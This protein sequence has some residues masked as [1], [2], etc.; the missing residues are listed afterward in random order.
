LSTTL[1]DRRPDG[2]TARLLGPPG[3]Q[4]TRLA[5]ALLSWLVYAL[6]AAGQH[7]EVLMGLVDERA[8]WQLTAFYMTGSTLFCLA[9]RSGWNERLRDPSMTVAQGV[10]GIVA[11][12]WSYAIT[13]PARGALLTIPMTILMFAMF[14]LGPRGSAV[15]SGATLLLFASVMGWKAHSDPL[16]YDPRVEVVH[17]VFALIVLVSL[18]VLAR[19]LTSLRQRLTRQRTEL[20]EALARIQQLATQDELTGLA[21]RRSMVE[22]LALEA[23][24]HQRAGTTLALAMIDLDHFKRIND[25]HGHGAGDAVLRGFAERARL[26]LRRHDV[27]ARWGGEEFVLLMPDTALAQ[28][29]AGLL[30][31]RERT[32]DPPF[33]EAV[34]GLRITFSAGL[35]DC[36]GPAD[37]DAAL[38]RADRAMYLAKTGGR[39][40]CVT[41]RSPAAAAQALSA[42]TAPTA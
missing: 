37:L 41:L 31:L 23:D 24:R 27:M 39:D 22:R 5:H 40:R 11:V 38:E 12:A 8:S 20:T 30:R 18:W 21:N 3:P 34:P 14:K 25:G 1:P 32:G 4:R 16:R 28:A 42:A 35:T 7:A 17:L 9:V 36:Q 15:F 10:L 13:G 2:L 6:F 26:A 19:R 29:E 33:D